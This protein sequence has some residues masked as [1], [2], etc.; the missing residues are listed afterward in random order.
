VKA[1]ATWAAVAEAAV[2]AV[3][4][5]AAVAE[6]TA[7]AVATWEGAAAEAAAMEAVTWEA[8]TAAAAVT[9]RDTMAGGIAE[10]AMATKRGATTR[11]GT[12]GTAAAMTTTGSAAMTM[13]GATGATAGDDA[14]AGFLDIPRERKRRTP[15]CAFSRPIVPGIRDQAVP[16][17]FRN[18]RATVFPSS[19]Q[20]FSTSLSGRQ[21]LFT[22]SAGI[23]MFM[24][25]SCSWMNF[26]PSPRQP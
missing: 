13:T 7:M 24:D 17:A 22:G 14:F 15:R 10:A 6:E 18:A 11:E 12:T 21:R 16:Q 1:V 19:L 5:W 20:A 26:G 9:R 25:A 3:A 2:K 4:T 8:A 23:A